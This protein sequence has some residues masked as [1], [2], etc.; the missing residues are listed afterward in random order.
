MNPRLFLTVGETLVASVRP[1]PPAP[2]P[3]CEAE[4][5][6]AT[7]RA[8]YAA[9]LTALEFLEWMGVRVTNNAQCHTGVQFAL[10][11]SGHTT[12]VQVASAL[13]TLAESRRSADYDMS[14]PDVGR[15]GQTDHVLQSARTVITLLDVLRQNRA[16][17]PFDAKAVAN[18]ILTY[19]TN[20]ALANIRRV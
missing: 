9:F 6:S 17:P 11:N 16:T 20:N 2:A 19:A 18:V 14:D 5:R 10:N 4:C 15:I 8:Y 3:P 13:N 7:S 12:L 1:Q